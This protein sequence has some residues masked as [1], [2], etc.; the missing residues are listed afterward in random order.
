MVQKNILASR[1]DK[2]IYRDGDR[3][4]KLFDESYSKSSIFNEALNQSRVAELGLNVPKIQE[5]T[6]IGGKSA[7]VM[8]FIEGETLEELL[9]KYPEKRAEFLALF[10]RVQREIHMKKH[11]LLTKYADK[12]KMKILQSD[13]AAS[14]RYDLAMRLDGMSRHTHVLHGDY[15]PSNFIL[16]KDG[17]PYVVD[18]SHASQ[19]NSTADA[20]KTYLLLMSGELKTFA[21]EYRT[22]FCKMAHS[23]EQYFDEWLPLV[24][25]AQLIRAATPER[26]EFLMH[27]VEESAK[28]EI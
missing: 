8:E 5:V 17:T 21:E 25:A 27:Y 10:V 13:L 15:V 14:T 23:S 7:I 19:G 20:A 26:R 18:W 11:L 16:K 1:S 24:A 3:L 2:T 22:E 4:I 9:K 6:V 12:L 28:D